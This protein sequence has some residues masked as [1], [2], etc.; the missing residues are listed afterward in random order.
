MRD[1]LALIMNCVLLLIFIKS[2][3]YKLRS[4]SPNMPLWGIPLVYLI[5]LS[6]ETFTHWFLFLARFQKIKKQTARSIMLHFHEQCSMLQLI[7]S[8]RETHKKHQALV[9][10]T[11][12]LSVKGSFAVTEPFSL[13][14]F[15]E[16]L[17][18]AQLTGDD[19]RKMAQLS[20]IIPQIFVFLYY[21]KPLHRLVIWEAV[22]VHTKTQRICYTLHVHYTSC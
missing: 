17:N 19:F 21:W 9:F 4:T 14:W 7:E 5:H 11:Q 22:F 6:I 13:T 16:I 10:L 1:L 18:Y 8:F 2:L 15:D 12:T 3:T 20:Y